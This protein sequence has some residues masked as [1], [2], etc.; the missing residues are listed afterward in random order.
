MAEIKAFG[1]LRFAQTAGNIAELVCPPYDIISEEERTAYLDRN[2]HNII[3]LELPKDG[4]NPYQTAGDTLAQWLDQGIAAC[5]NEDAIYVYE[6]SFTALGQQ[7]SIKGIICRVKLEE[8]DKGVV[9]PHEETLSK[10]KQDRFNL[11]SATGC[12]FSCI[13]SLYFDERAAIYPNVETGSTAA[14]VYEFTTADG[15]IHRMW[16]ITDAALV[17]AIT[18][19][20]REKK[21]YIADGHHRYETALNYRNHLRE[22][23]VITDDAHPA[24]Y[25][26]MMLVNM[27]NPGL[28]VYPTHR[29]LHGLEGFDAQKLLDGCG[30]YFDVTDCPVADMDAALGRHADAGEKAMAFY[31]D[32]AAKLLTLRDRHA[33]EKL[34]PDKSAAYCGLD[35]TVLHSLVLERLLGIDKARLAAQTNLTYTRDTAEALALVDSGKADCAFIIN[36]TRVD[37]I[38]AVAGAGEK[39]PQKSTY[40][41]PKIITG[42]VMN[43]LI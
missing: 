32:G 34:L 43:K 27:E 16:R 3:R 37:E 24:N 21:L 2:P 38:A 15:I 23:G 31:H 12:N 18:D 17:S 35:V 5:D 13:Y 6:E 40:F 8:F 30:A 4:E 19:G 26:M 41:Y 29:V 22:T 33:A 9:L 20:F 11:M 42:H 14:P 28:V 7:K 25:V 10:A 1:A 36:P 39:M